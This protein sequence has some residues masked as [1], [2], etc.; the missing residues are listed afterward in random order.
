[1]LCMNFMLLLSVPRLQDIS[2]LCFSLL[3]FISVLPAGIF[4]IPGI[5][6][7]PNPCSLHEYLP[8]YDDSRS[9]CTRIVTKLAF[10]V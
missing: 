2:F 6:P 9:E 3:D 1:M 7:A 10:S 4:R 8:I 5:F